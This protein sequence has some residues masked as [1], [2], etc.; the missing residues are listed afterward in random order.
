MKMKF[1]FLLSVC[2]L[3]FGLGIAHGATAAAVS[4]SIR[5]GNTLAV[6]NSTVEIPLTG[7]VTVTDSDGVQHMASNQSV[8]ALLTLLDESSGAFFVSNLQYFSSFNSLYVKCITVTAISQK[9]CDN[10]QYAVNGSIPQVAMDKFMVSS[11]DTIWL[12]FGDAHR[13]KLDTHGIDAGQSFVA[14][15]ENYRFQNNDWLVLPGITI[16]VTQENRSDPFS[17]IEV[18]TS[19]ANEYGQATF[20]VNTPGEYLIGIKEDF[21]FP[22][23]PLTVGTPHASGG[24]S[25][26][27]SAPPAQ[28]QNISTHFDVQK[29]VKFLEAQQKSDGSF[30]AP[31]FSD[32]VAVALGASQQDGI[33]RD[34]LKSYLLQDSDPGNL[35]TDAERRAMA[36]MALGIDPA[37]G[38]ST[39]YI[40]KILDGFDGTQFGDAN[41]VNDDVFA[42]L[43]L[44]KAGFHADARLAKDLAFIL[45]KQESD[46]SFARSPDMTAAAIQTISLFQGESDDINSAIGRA[47]QYLK[48]KQEKG[49]GFENV[50]ATAWVLQAIFALKEVPQDWAKDDKTPL[51][52]LASQQREDGSIS[53][54][55]GGSVGANDETPASPAGGVENRIWA[56]AYAV[57]AALGKPWGDILTSFDISAVVEKAT[58]VQTIKPAEELA[59]AKTVPEEYGRLSVQITQLRSEVAELKN[60]I[61]TASMLLASSPASQRGESQGGPVQES[62]VRPKNLV[63]SLMY[64]AI[65]QPII[66]A[67]ALI[68]NLIQ[69]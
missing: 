38:T 3:V 33:A 54:P 15:A 69:K 1:K 55:Q 65:V 24:V 47:K 11:A 2:T 68:W 4:F 14:T 44:S 35:L 62:V 23:V 63:A 58:A 19:S 67:L 21:Y 30:G 25:V 29:A 6:Q 7:S 43:V 60:S 50:Y 53:S 10:W 66:S 41:L 26:F 46:G 51:D 39:N 52:V 17:P 13:V 34:K 37:Q 40:K 16:G 36:L 9:F 28:K 49:G 57:P 8:L 27:S 22:T 42:L 48:L 18:L 64:T 5:S 56:T 12:F 45:S 20:T 59:T 32:W 31:L 61:E